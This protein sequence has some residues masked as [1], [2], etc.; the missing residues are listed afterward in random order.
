M[1]KR[2]Q[3]QELEELIKPHDLIDTLDSLMKN[4][5][6]DSYYYDFEGGEVELEIPDNVVIE[7]MFNQD[8]LPTKGTI[9]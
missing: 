7:E 6:L 8:T 4:G 2:F 9:H 3:I 5:K 1:T